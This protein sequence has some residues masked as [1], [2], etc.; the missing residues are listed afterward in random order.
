MLIDRC[1]VGQGV[2]FG[3]RPFLFRCAQRTYRNIQAKPL[4]SKMAP[5]LAGRGWASDQ[6]V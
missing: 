2:G 1:V 5:D 3:R 4:A 6:T